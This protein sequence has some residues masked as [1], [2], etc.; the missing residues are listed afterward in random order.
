MKMEWSITSIETGYKI[1]TGCYFLLKVSSLL[2]FLLTYISL[3]F[4]ISEVVSLKLLYTCTRTIP[5]CQIFWIIR[6][7]QFVKGLVCCT[8]LLKY[9][10]PSFGQTQLIVKRK[11]WGRAINCS[12]ISV[13]PIDSTP[14]ELY[15]MQHFIFITGRSLASF[16]PDHSVLLETPLL[17]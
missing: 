8:V 6:L 12:V 1:H 9:H 7:N 16:E 15:C 2:F 3:V 14:T 5:M 13:F 11:T 17:L 10:E 4:Y